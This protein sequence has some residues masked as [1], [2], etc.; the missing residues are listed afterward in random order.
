MTKCVNKDPKVITA[1]DTLMMATMGGAKAL[2]LDNIKGS[3]TE[4]KD[5]DIVIFD[6]KSIDM[7]PVIDPINDIVYNSNCNDVD[8]VICKG[9]IVVLKGK[10]TK[11]NE[12]DLYKKCSLLLENINER[13]KHNNK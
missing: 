13:C 8:T 5:A 10:C 11:I 7:F 3:I 9:E 2:K 6:V 4:G 1:Y 12:D